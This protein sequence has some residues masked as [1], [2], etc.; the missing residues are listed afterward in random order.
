MREATKHG[1]QASLRAQI[2]RINFCLLLETRS[3]TEHSA[4]KKYVLVEF[5]DI[6]LASLVPVLTSAVLIAPVPRCVYLEK[7]RLMHVHC[8]HEL[9]AENA[10]LQ[11]TRRDTKE[12]KEKK[13][14]EEKDIAMVFGTT[15][16]HVYGLSESRLLEGASPSRFSYVNFEGPC[17]STGMRG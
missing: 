7:Q 14:K 13:E 4:L 10:N 16:S 5:V 17:S 2:S 8:H 15:S 12:K 11:K 9:I 3:R 1:L 6:S